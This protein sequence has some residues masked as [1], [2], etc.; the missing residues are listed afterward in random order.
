MGYGKMSNKF[1][2]SIR[3]NRFS[4]A[5]GAAFQKSVHDS[6]Q[7]VISEYKA[8]LD[9][10]GGVTPEIIRSALEP[11]FDLSQQYVPVEFGTLRDSGFLEIT[12]DG[13]VVMGY[14]KGGVPDYA[15]FVHERMDQEHQPPTRSKFLQAALD[16]DFTNVVQR[17]EEKLGEL[18]R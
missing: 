12:K 7:D 15:P 3:T 5:S 16:E 11:T 18:F 14:G 10:I 6:M 1:R 13:T 2:A 17:I 9:F 8:F 4:G